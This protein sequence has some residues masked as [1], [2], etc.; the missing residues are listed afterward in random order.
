MARS[1]FSKGIGCSLSLSLSLGVVVIINIKPNIYHILLSILSI[2][3]IIFIIYYNPS[4]PHLP[5]Q[6]DHQE[7]QL[8][9]QSLGNSL[10][11]GRGCFPWFLDVLGL[12]EPLKPA[13]LVL[14]FSSSISD[15]AR[16]DRPSTFGVEWS[17]EDPHMHH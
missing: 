13:L 6:L 17:H 16:V 5:F 7:E 9:F 11:T 10:V 1:S 8:I 12:P 14:H 3:D 4:N 15:Q 2:L